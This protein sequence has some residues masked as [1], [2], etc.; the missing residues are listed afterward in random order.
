MP[1]RDESIRGFRTAKSFPDISAREMPLPPTP[2]APPRR[3]GKTR[4][5]ELK[6]NCNFKNEILY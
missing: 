1:T 2:H 6:S 5:G 3:D 4:A